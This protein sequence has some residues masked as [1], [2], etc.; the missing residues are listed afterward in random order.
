MVHLWL[1]PP[2]RRKPEVAKSVALG[3]KLVGLL[4]GLIDVVT[5]FQQDGALLHLFL[6]TLDFVE[7]FFYRLLFLCCFEFASA[8]L[9]GRS[10]C[11]CIGCLNSDMLHKVLHHCSE[12]S[13]CD[14]HRKLIVS[15]AAMM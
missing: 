7:S 14:R 8:G 11:R 3:G 10:N 4:V 9:A 5:V 2:V 12:P 15:S 13:S 1:H 6:R